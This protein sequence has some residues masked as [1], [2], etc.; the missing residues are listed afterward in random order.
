MSNKEYITIFHFLF[1]LIYDFRNPTYCSYIILKEKEKENTIKKKEEEKK[2]KEIEQIIKENEI[3]ILN[4]SNENNKEYDVALNIGLIG[5]QSGGKTSISKCY[6]DN[7]PLENN[8]YYQ[9]TIGLDFFIKYL[10]IKD[11]VIYVK[12]WDNTGQERFN[13]ITSGYLRG[14][15]GCFIVF[16]IPIEKVLKI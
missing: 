4:I 12:I 8:N 1:D 13:S 7:K 16:D 6:Q 9:P 3:E 15:H 2:E 5:N 11:E 10:K 14:L